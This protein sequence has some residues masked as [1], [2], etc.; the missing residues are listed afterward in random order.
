VV[1]LDSFSGSFLMATAFT[2]YCSCGKVLHFSHIQV[3]ISQ[4][5]LPI[6]LSGIESEAAPERETFCTS[7]DIIACASV[8]IQVACN[9]LHMAHNILYGVD[10]KGIQ[11]CGSQFIQG[12]RH[13]AN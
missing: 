11:H 4:N 5:L 10:L 9:E 2:S 13:I 6:Q 8:S 3:L 7:M 1:V 12:K